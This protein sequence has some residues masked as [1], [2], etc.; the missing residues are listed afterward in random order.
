MLWQN[1]EAN[2]IKPRRM[3]LTIVLGYLGL[4]V[5]AGM[6][7]FC[8][9][10]LCWLDAFF[11]GLSAVTLTGCS[12]VILPESLPDWILVW[13]S[14]V[15][16][17]CGYFTILLFVTLLPRVSHS[18]NLMFNGDLGEFHNWRMLPEW[19][20]AIRNFALLYG[21]LTIFTFVGLS[22]FGVPLWQGFHYALGTA[23]T[24][25]FNVQNG[26]IL[27]GLG[28]GGKLFFAGT[29][30]LAGGNYLFYYLLLKRGFDKKNFDEEFR[31]YFG[32]TIA[33]TGFIAFNLW[34][35]NFG[36]Y[37]LTD[38]FCQV[39]SFASTTGYMFINC[40]A[41]PVFS[42]FVLVLFLFVG[43]CAGSTAGGLKMGRCLVLLKQFNWDVNVIFHPQMVEGV[44]FNGR[45]IIASV[46]YMIS[47]YFFAHLLMVVIVALGLALNDCVAVEAIFTACAALS[48]CGGGM[49]MASMSGNLA[50]FSVLGKISLV[51]GMLVG[52]LE[53]F[54]PL[55]FLLPEFWQRN[56]DW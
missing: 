14:I 54:I 41:W 24:A 29:M 46:C 32:L 26:L 8:C 31:F 44:L 39:S 55:A 43:G 53:I 5:L 4:A 1:N 21:G 38:I 30:L 15:Q 37:A 13:R 27:Q 22:L 17:V 52:R 23:S 16:W 50:D 56:K 49:S 45:R 19:G 40:G 51:L 2:F 33:A 12:T 9:G 42:R 35:L 25:G 3:I 10:G 48:N 18:S 6:P 36:G 20:G 11:E 47:F 34:Y 28:S 7:Y